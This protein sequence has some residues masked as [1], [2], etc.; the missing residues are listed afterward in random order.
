MFVIIGN[1]NVT[2]ILQNN[3]MQKSTTTPSYDA[4]CQ[5]LESQSIYRKKQ[6]LF[7]TTL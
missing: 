4:K 2:F 1:I 5:S 7:A 6:R 3:I